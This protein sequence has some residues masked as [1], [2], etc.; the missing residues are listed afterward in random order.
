[1]V[2]VI[3]IARHNGINT[4]IFLVIDGDHAYLAGYHLTNTEDRITAPGCPCCIDTEIFHHIAMII[5]EQKRSGNI[6]D[7]VGWIDDHETNASI[8]ERKGVK[9]LFYEKCAKSASLSEEARIK[10]REKAIWSQGRYL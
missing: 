5:L 9:T 7:K 6:I 2:N 8:P 1:M 4:P 10:L 3:F